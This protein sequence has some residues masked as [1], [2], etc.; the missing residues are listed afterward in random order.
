[1]KEKTST[2]LYTVL[3]NG[4]VRLVEATT[5]A[6]AIQHCAAPKYVVNIAKPKDIAALMAKGVKVEVATPETPQQGEL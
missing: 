4:T 5:P 6:Q 1:M 3:D 2:R